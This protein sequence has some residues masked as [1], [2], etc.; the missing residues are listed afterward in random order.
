MGNPIPVNSTNVLGKLD[1]QVSG[2]DQLSIRY[3]LYYITATIREAR[4][5]S[6][7]RAHPRRSTTSIKRSR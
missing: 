1:H 5:A 6:V 3:S 7:R 2:E 4:A